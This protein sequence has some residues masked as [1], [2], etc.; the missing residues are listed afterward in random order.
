[1]NTKYD[2]VLLRGIEAPERESKLDSPWK[3]IRILNAGVSIESL[4]DLIDRLLQ[5]DR[6]ALSSCGWV[7]Y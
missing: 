3:M 4:V 5:P 1:M 7:M 2:V 6:Q